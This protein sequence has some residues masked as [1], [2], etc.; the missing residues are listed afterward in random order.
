MQE[1]RWLCI[2]GVIVDTI[3]TYAGV[4]FANPHQ[5]LFFLVSELSTPTTHTREKN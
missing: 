2:K 3:S 1:S 5:G 4:G